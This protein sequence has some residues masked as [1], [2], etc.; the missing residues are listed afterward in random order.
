MAPWQG[1]EAACLSPATLAPAPPQGPSLKGS[2][3]TKAWS[4][5]S[6]LHVALSAM[7]TTVQGVLSARPGRGQGS[8]W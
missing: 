7:T 8:V 1:R 6:W 3:G 2:P 5:G 4:G